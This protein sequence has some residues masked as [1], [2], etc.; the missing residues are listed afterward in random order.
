VDPPDGRVPP[1]TPEARQRTAM[2]A[3][4]G[5]EQADH[6]EERSIGERCLLFSAGPPLTPGPYNN[7]L[8]IVQTR[9]AVMLM[10]EMIHDARVVP[11]DGRPQL[12]ASIRLWLGSSRGRW[13]GD[14][15][16]VETTNFTAKTSVRGSDERLHLVER[17]TLI[18]RDALRYEYTVDNPTAFTR[19][20]TAAFMLMR[21][22][23]PMFEFACHEGNVAMEHILRGARQQEKAGR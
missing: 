11:L 7:N 12:P 5:P 6:P 13:E 21:T 9:D 4:Q 2:R 19:P 3:P 17:F 16:V 18:G 20:W 1:L 22:A 14:T 10:T 8:Q 15:L 23:E